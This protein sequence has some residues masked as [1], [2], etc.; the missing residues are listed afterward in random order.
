MHRVTNHARAACVCVVDVHCL[1][2]KR[3]PFAKGKD[4]PLSGGLSPSARPPLEQRHGWRDASSQMQEM[5][6]K[7]QC[8]RLGHAPCCGRISATAPWSSQEIA[9]QA[10]WMGQRC[11]KRMG[12]KGEEKTVASVVRTAT[13]SS[14][15]LAC[16]SDAEPRRALS[17]PWPNS[18][19]PRH[20]QMQRETTTAFSPGAGT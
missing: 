18:S 7:A 16:V 12:G 13:P 11:T 8:F 19:R 10:V 17:S 4:P 20:L 15:S 5:A 14:M 1:R 3:K 9:C 6:S 2:L